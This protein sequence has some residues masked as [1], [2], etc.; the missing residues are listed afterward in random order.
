LKFKEFFE[1]LS[2]SM[3]QIANSSK[4]AK[5]NI[6]PGMDDWADFEID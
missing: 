3:G 1:W 4:E 5:V 2:K 6:S